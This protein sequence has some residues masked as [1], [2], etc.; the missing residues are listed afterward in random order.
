MNPI[1][2]EITMITKKRIVKTTA[3]RQNQVRAFLRRKGLASIAE[4]ARAVDVSEIHAWRLIDGL[5]KKKQVELAYTEP[6]A[7]NGKRRNIYR[8][9][10]AYL[11][12]LRRARESYQPVTKRGGDDLAAPAWPP[13]FEPPKSTKGPKPWYR[14]ILGIFSGST[15]S[16][17][18][19]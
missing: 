14:R 12:T 3:Q 6:T 5:A 11:A 16:R 18:S 9:T 2:Q 19:A 8:L 10:D 1:N 7:S 15:E 4:V 17:A 13:A